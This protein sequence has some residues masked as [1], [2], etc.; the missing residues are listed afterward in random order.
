MLERGRWILVDRKAA[1]EQ[2]DRCLPVEL[3]RGA[4]RQLPPR[5]QIDKPDGWEQCA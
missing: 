4:S 5:Q 1:A 3:C 2:D